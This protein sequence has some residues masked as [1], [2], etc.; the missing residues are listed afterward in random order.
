MLVSERRA[1]AF[2]CVVGAR[3]SGGGVASFVRSLFLIATMVRNPATAAFGPSRVASVVGLVGE[4]AAIGMRARIGSII[5]SSLL[6]TLMI[7]T[8]VRK[9]AATARGSRRM[10]SGGLP[11]EASALGMCARSNSRERRSGRGVDNFV[12]CVRRVK[13]YRIFFIKTLISMA[14]SA[15]RGALLVLLF[16]RGVDLAAR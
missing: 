5:H 10:G 15:D 11:G 2:S 7:A 4:A 8:S 13:R 16:G 14:S 6:R 12:R 3:C 9:P 1:S